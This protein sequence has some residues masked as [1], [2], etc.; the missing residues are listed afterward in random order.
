MRVIYDGDVF[1]ENI[2]KRLIAHIYEAALWIMKNPEKSIKDAE[3]IPGRE[4]EE[5]L[6][7]FN[8]T[9]WPYD[10]NLMMKDLLEEAAEKYGDNTAVVYKDEK[11]TYR[12]LNEKANTLARVL[13]EKGIGRGKTAGIFIDRSVEMVIAVIAVVKAGGVYIPVDHEYPPARIEYMLK[14]SDADILLTLPSLAEK[15]NFEGTVLYLDDEK[16]Y[17]GDS[18]NLSSING[19]E[20]AV[21]IIYTSGSTGNPKG[22][23]T[24]HLGLTHF[25]L[26]YKETR[27]LTEKDNTTKFVSFGFDVTMWEI[28]PTLMSGAALHI[29]ESDISLSPYMLNDYFEKTILP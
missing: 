24:K 13:R 19:P 27:N 29:I 6:Y 16:L 21:T 10:R 9:E 8:H 2:I 20:D 3:I 15:V 18:S 4:K 5:L 22:V 11:I 17:E 7:R 14:D 12:E 28:F 23:I 1:E 25:C 26:W